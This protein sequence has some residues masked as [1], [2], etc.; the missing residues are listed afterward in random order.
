[1]ILLLGGKSEKGCQAAPA[2]RMCSGSDELDAHAHQPTTS[3][4]AYNGRPM[5]ARSFT[6]A[7]PIACLSSHERGLLVTRVPNPT[8]HTSDVRCA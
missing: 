5:L 6:T 4:P 8:P 2:A 3:K 7:K 1:M